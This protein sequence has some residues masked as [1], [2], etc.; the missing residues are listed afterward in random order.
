MSPVLQSGTIHKKPLLCGGEDCS[1]QELKQQ[2]ICAFVVLFGF[3]WRAFLFA[4]HGL[5]QLKQ[6]FCHLSGQSEHIR[7][8]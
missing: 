4:S 7:L 6:D 8:P 2:R 3:A 5:G 1:K